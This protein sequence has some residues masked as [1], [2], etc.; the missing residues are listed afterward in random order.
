MVID[1]LGGSLLTVSEV[2][3]QLGVAHQRVHKL[4]ADG[5][6]GAQRAGRELLLSREEVDRFV[7]TR[8]MSAGRPLSQQ[9]AWD[10]IFRLGS[11]RDWEGFGEWRRRLRRRA[12]H[13]EVYVHPSLLCK[14]D[15]R[16]FKSSLGSASMADAIVFGGRAAAADICSAVGDSTTF[17]LYVSRFAED[18]VLQRLGAFPNRVDPNVFMHVVNDDVWPYAAGEP[19]TSE[20]VAWLD[21]ADRD[22]RGLAV[23]EQFLLSQRAQRRMS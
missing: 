7:L 20:W 5:V 9:G 16:S 10:Q 23:F 6:L 14:G 4:I 18:A 21:L 12:E 22:D 2:A 8:D 11:R 13:R 17:D 15:V 3:E 19:F 1:R